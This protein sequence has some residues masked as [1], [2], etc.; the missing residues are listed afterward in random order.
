MTHNIIRA[1]IQRDGRWKEEM[2]VFHEPVSEALALKIANEL[3][4]AVTRT[5]GTTY[6]VVRDPQ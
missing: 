1:R 4:E 3:M 6:F 5:P 2:T